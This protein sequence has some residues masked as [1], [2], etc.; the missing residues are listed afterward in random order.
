MPLEEAPERLAYRGER[1]M[2]RCGALTGLRGRP[3]AAGLVF[4]L[5]FYS[6][7]FI[8]QLKR[9]RKTATIR[10][11]DKSKKYRK[12]EVVMITVGFQ[13][14]P[15]ERIFEAVIDSVEVK[16]VSDLSPRDIEHDNPEFRRLDEMVHFLEQ[17]YG[18]KIEHGDDVTVVRFSQISDRP[19]EIQRAAFAQTPR[20]N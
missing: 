19:S 13:H 9:G 11:G 15:R 17:I 5:N 12:G 8:D 4:V 6:P 3:Q 20:K 2:V 1:E 16:R 18:R 14:S 10:L 7:V